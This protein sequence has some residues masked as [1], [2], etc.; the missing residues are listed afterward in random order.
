MVLV[1]GVGPSLARFGIDGTAGRPAAEDPRA[2]DG[3]QVLAGNDDWGQPTVVNA[4][5]VTGDVIP[6]PP[7][8]A[9]GALYPG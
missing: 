7:T 1:R 9:V 6:V 8:A 4:R 2:G 5:A 3:T